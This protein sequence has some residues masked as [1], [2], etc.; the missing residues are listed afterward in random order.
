MY[1]F[2]GELD[3]KYGKAEAQAIYKSC[4]RLFALLP[5]A[6][7][8]NRATLVMHGGLFRKPT[9]A[10]PSRVSSA[11]SLC[12]STVSECPLLYYALLRLDLSLFIGTM[13][14]SITFV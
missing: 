7:V 9:V 8:I 12:S 5:L 6:A 10:V 3:Q 2:K 4:K 14:P 13:F 11:T 1:G